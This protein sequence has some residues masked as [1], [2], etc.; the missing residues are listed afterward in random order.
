[1]SDDS[2]ASFDRAASRIE[3]DVPRTDEPEGTVLPCERGRV[4]VR[5]VVKDE[6]FKVV[7]GKPYR[8]LAGD[9]IFSGTIPEGGVIDHLVKEAANRARLEVTVGPNEKW[10]WDLKIAAMDP[11]ELDTGM[12]ARLQNLAL[13]DKEPATKEDLAAAAVELYDELGVPVGSED[14][15]AALSRAY[16]AEDTD[17]SEVEDGD[18]DFLDAFIA[19]REALGEEPKAP[20][21]QEG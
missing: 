20:V 5:V 10:T 18:H 11:V 21:G 7:R 4:R 2:L 1:M 17:L 6:H 15:R 9:E 8:L 19:L 3:A 12:A 14:A 13:A 16:S